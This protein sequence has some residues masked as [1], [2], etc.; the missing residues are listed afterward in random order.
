MSSLQA[1]HLLERSKLVFHP[2]DDVEH[3]DKFQ[4]ILRSF[5]R[6]MRREMRGLPDDFRP[7]ELGFQPEDT[8][9]LPEDIIEAVAEESNIGMNAI[10]S[11]RRS[12][13]VAR[14]RQV[15]MYLLRDLTSLSFPRIGLRLGG[16][17]HTTVIHGVKAVEKRL[18]ECADTIRLVERVKQRVGV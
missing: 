15:A 16:F 7:Q 4:A 18:Q 3:D 5:R 10:R 2:S 1:L 13:K 17:D 11:K 12:A 8:P 9:L 14:P 6:Q